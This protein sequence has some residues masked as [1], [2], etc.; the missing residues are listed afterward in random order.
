VTWALAIGQFRS[1]FERQR[2]AV[3]V[4]VWETGQ[5]RRLSEIIQEVYRSNKEAGRGR[6][7]RRR[8]TTTLLVRVDAS[9]CGVLEGRR[10][11]KNR[12]VNNANV[13]ITLTCQSKND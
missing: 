9:G 5:S 11:A 13:T 10:S 6:V 12:G 1:V 4:A 3:L 8:S 7:L 2:D